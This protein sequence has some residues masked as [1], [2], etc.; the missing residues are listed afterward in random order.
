MPL[1]EQEVLKVDLVLV[2]VRLL[3]T[4]DQVTKFSEAVGEDVVPA[5]TGLV[6]RADHGNPEQATRLELPKDRI[7]LELSSGRSIIERDYPT[8]HELSRFADI[9]T[10]ATDSSGL[11]NVPP[12]GHGYNLAMV[13]RQDSGEGALSYLGKRL[14]G[15]VTFAAQGWNPVGGTGRLMYESPDG[16]WEFVVEPRLQKRDTD[17]VFLHLNLYREQTTIPGRE[18]IVSALGLIW[19]EAHA[20]ANRIHEGARA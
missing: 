10:L 6:L 8:E 2:G 7:A 18:E 12:R 15:D 11:D 19:R 16:L 9:V 5:G 3:P 1:C 13:Y 20:L 14:F 17:R 4:P